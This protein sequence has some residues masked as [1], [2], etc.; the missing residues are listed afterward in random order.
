MLPVLLSSEKKESLT[1]SIC[2]YAITT[3]L[4]LTSVIYSIVIIVQL[5]VMSCGKAAYPYDYNRDKGRSVHLAY[6]EFIYFFIDNT[7]DN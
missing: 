6:I 3:L 1:A 7:I 5:V 2:L 4:L